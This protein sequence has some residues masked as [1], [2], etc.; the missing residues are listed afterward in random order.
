MGVQRDGT[1]III[2]MKDFI[3]DL[4]INESATSV[5][6]SN[7]G[8]K[9]ENSVNVREDVTITIVGPSGLTLSKTALVGLDEGIGRVIDPPVG[10]LATSGRST[11][12]D[13]DANTA[14]DATSDVMHFVTADLGT[15]AFPR[16]YGQRLFSIFLGAGVVGTGY[17]QRKG[18][19]RIDRYDNTTNN[20]QY[21]L[22]LMVSEGELS[23]THG[24]YPA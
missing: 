10:A 21:T 6:T 8:S 9:T 3:T 22:V 12:L 1:P 19:V 14:I 23:K 15:G 16:D 13:L 11:F 5:P 18:V 2:D 7:A 20:A 4:T 17:V 24:A